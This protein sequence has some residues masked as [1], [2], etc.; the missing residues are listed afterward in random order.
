MAGGFGI[1]AN[2]TGGRFG[3]FLGVFTPSVLTI[4]GVIMYLRFGWVV[5]CAGLGGAIVI[6]VICCAI[7]FFTALSASA[8]ATNSRFGTGG[9]YYMISRSL[10]LT[11]GGAI[12]IPLF[13]CYVP[14]ITLYCFGLAEALSIFWPDAWGS[15]PL[16][17]MAGGLI[18]LIIIVSGKSASLALRLQIPLMVLVGLSLMALTAGVFSGPL[19]SP[20]WVAPSV[21]PSLTETGG[22]WAILAVFFPAVT[23]FSAGIGMSGDLKDPQKAIPRGTL[24]AVSI[25]TLVYL[26]IPFLL[27]IT[28][29]VTVEQ[30]ATEPAV[31]T[32]IA[33]FGGVLIYPGL[34]GAILSSAFGSAL[35][36]PRILQAL[37]QDRLAPTFLARTSKTGQPTIATWV[38]GVIA[39]SAVAMG[40]LNTVARMVTILFLTLYM[41]E[42]LVATMEN[43]VR[44]PSY[45]PTL[46]IHW[47]VS[48]LGVIGILVVMMLISVKI[49]L[50]AIALEGCLWAYL[51]RKNLVT[52]WGD[53]WAGLWGSLSRFALRRLTQQVGD[54]RSWR[55][56]ILLF[57]DQL[58][59]RTGQ[60][61]MA[62][63]F[64]QNRGILTV[65]DV[66]AGSPAENAEIVSDRSE[67]MA[68][69][70]QREGIVAFSEVDV[71]E[72]F[73][74]GALNIVQA[75]GIGAMRANTVAFGWPSRAE[76]LQSLLK[77][78][79]QL[80]GI[81]KASLIIHPTPP[82][83]PQRFD[84]IDIWWRGKYNNGDLMLL[85]AYLLSVNPLW[86]EAHINLRTIVTKDMIR[87]DIEQSLTALIEAVRIKATQDVIVLEEGKSVV[88]T[89]QE[90]S[91]DADVVFLGLMPPEAGDEEEYANR[92]IEILE[93]LPTAV[94][95]HN[96]GP[97]KGQLL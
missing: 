17:W 11:I 71:M 9:E 87:P 8:V 23:G 36:G 42:N 83:G 61:R 96:S 47:S 25:G 20:Q 19:K 31:W 59:K 7:A 39:L 32:K 50:C 2:R 80:A 79:R 38:A 90:T 16:Q 73:E 55:P 77:I 15:P 91:A 72:D 84:R 86:R 27:A 62:A 49:S 43:L 67:K 14:S 4:L 58:E 89:M 24:W 12:G 10:G 34:W 46:R 44:N 33:L 60:L 64:N 81:G 94:L 82:E 6:V 18:V 69:I 22:F 48:M 41:S 13:L 54:P 78:I 30:L 26:A 93:P 74:S 56:N 57:A 53:V 95:V 21:S 35:A 40:S 97:F 3:A 70:L 52:T 45:R 5:A 85:L 37:A 1:L 63:W 76:K 29:R 88:E 65:C 51:R 92:L 66:I 75:N 68:G 28:G